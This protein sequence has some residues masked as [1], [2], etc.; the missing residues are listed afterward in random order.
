MPVQG[1]TND[2]W[3]EFLK[4]SAMARSRNPEISRI[5]VVRSREEGM[6][7]PAPAV[8]AAAYSAGVTGQPAVSK[9]RVL[10]NRFD[11]YA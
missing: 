8:H 6:R 2:S 7:A 4:L 9:P 3:A 1:I 10:G 11:V 5:P